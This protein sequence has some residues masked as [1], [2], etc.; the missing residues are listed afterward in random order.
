MSQHS[1]VVS[2]FGGTSMNDAHT[3]H[4]CAD[5]V[6]KQKSSLVVVSATSGTTNQL[7]DLGQ[8]SALKQ[9]LEA[10]KLV[11]LISQRHL[12]IAQNLNLNK[13]RSQQLND[14]LN[15]LKQ[16]SF[17][18]GLLKDASDRNLDSLVSL[19]ER[20]SS[21]LFSQALEN[22]LQKKSIQKK[23][24]WLDARDFIKTDDRFSRAQPVIDE[25]EKNCAKLKPELTQNIFVTQGFI[26]AT[27]SGQT[28]TLGRGG[29]DFS[30]ALFAE[31]LQADILEIW[32]DVAGIA[33]TDPRLVKEARMIPEI[34]FTEASELAT[35]GAKVLHPATLLPA[36]RKNIPVFVGSSFAPDQPGTW[37]RK[38][39]VSA[40]LVRALAL[41]NNQKLVT[42]T[43]PN[44]WQTHGFL[45][46]IFKVFNDSKISVDAITTSEIS[47]ALTLDSAQD[48]PQKAIDELSQFAEVQMESNLS[49]VSLI[50]NNVN[51]T[52]GLAEK[53][54]SVLKSMNVRMIC[55][56]AS[57]HNFCF[58]LEESLAPSAIQ[59]LHQHFIEN[60]RL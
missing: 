14:L 38:T 52:P 13:E 25:I 44:M 7:L 39:S 19:G 56:G 1:L 6:I 15:E 60:Q 24:L 46:Q 11:D 5:V 21:V 43:T 22:Q 12:Q 33:T 45:F 42:L 53:T 37:V 8:K 3:M 41:R 9:N 10:E 28:T 35:F 48:F 18:I 23:S 58:L 32:T 55:Q 20:M 2:K 40:P 57:R 16:L 27:L 49:L 59:K 51:F 34:S 36:M 54:F 31:G 47:V 4:L 29:S 30:A 50:G 17:G 26:G